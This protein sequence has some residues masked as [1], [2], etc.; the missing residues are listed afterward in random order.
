MDDTSLCP[1]VCKR[2]MDLQAASDHLIR[3]SHYFQKYI[4]TGFI[5]TW[6]NEQP[7]NR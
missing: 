2:I 1:S 3:I 5:R 4:P 6:V 7:L